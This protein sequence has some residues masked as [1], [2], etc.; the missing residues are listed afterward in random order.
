MIDFDSGKVWEPGDAA[1]LSPK[2][3]P[4][5]FRE[6]D[7]VSV[8]VTEVVPEGKIKGDPDESVSK[9]LDT[10]KFSLNEETTEFVLGKLKLTETIHFGQRYE[11]SQDRQSWRERH[12]E[13]CL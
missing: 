13:G 4:E 10:V 6:P 9:D 1:K 8:I 5:N 3:I 12:Y 7:N 2:S 11:W